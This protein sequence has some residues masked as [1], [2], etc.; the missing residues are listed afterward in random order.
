MFKAGKEMHKTNTYVNKASVD[1]TSPERK[2]ILKGLSNLMPEA[3]TACGTCTGSLL[4]TPRHAQGG[5]A[6]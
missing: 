6:N 1:Y 3:C 2:T 5:H 4:L